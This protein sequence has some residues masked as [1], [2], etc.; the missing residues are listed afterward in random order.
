MEKVAI[1]IDLGTTNS[2]VGV[3]NN[4][5]VELAEN[6]EGKVIKKYTRCC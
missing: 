5:K 2:A 1:G 3:W 4:G 6:K